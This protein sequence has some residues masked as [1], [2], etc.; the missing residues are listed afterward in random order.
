MTNGSTGAAGRAVSEIK[1]GWPRPG[2]RGVGV[3]GN[4]N[5]EK[6]ELETEHRHLRDSTAD[7]LS[8]EVLHVRIEWSGTTSAQFH[9]KGCHITTTEVHSELE[10]HHFRPS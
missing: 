10:D 2:E 7:D 8:R 9:W 1:V 4:G 6:A 5:E 3:K